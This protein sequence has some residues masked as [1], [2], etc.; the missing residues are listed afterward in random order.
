M[1][2]P[3]HN[4]F[5]VKFANVNGTG[6]SSANGMFM[7][8][9]FRMGIP[10]VG[11]NY[12]PSNI[13]GLPTWYEIRASEKGYLSPSG[14]V[15]IMVAMNAQTYAEDLASV[16][17]GGYL[18]YDSSW[19]RKE[20]MTREDVT[21]LGVPLA[22]ICNEKFDTA[23]SRT[24][25]KNTAYVG[26]LAALLDM[27][28]A[29]IEQLLLDT[30]GA[31]KH[32]IDANKIALDM[33]FDYA[34]ENFKCPL[35]F[36]AQTTNKTD[37]HIIIDGNATAA[38]G[39]VFAGATVGSWYP[40][41]PST[42]LMDAFSGYCQSLRK[43]KETEKNNYSIIQA[44]DEL[45]AIGMA[46]GAGWNGARS[47]TPTSGPGISLMGEFLGF[48][49]YAEIP[50][51]VFD[52]QR[53]G[54]STGM[55]TRTQQCDIMAC[56][57]ASHGDTKH[58]CL[59]PANPE[60]AFYLSTEAFNLAEQLQTP[61]FVLSDLDIGMND[62]MVKD[63]EW[64]DGY[65]PKRG[66]VLGKEEL[67]EIETFYRYLDVDGDGITY[68][69][70]PGRH[71]KGAYFTRG[72]GHNRLGGYTENASD[73]QDVVDRLLVK[74]ETAK[75]LV[76]QPEISYSKKNKIGIISI[77]SCNDAI[78]ET[79]DV[80][81]KQGQALNYLRVKAFPF[82]DKVETFITQ[83]EQVFVIEQNRDGQLHHMLIAE[84]N[85]DPKKLKSLRFYNGIPIFAK[86]IIQQIEEEINSG[87]A[88]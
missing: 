34:K 38:L 49:Y 86:D 3:S 13:Q 45:A 37:G 39:C 76:P 55:P 10:V 21:V 75:T 44:E 65:E 15:D 85:A 78:R 29:V 53:T 40:I 41:T 5:T 84:T 58:V 23:R 7:K 61:V 26:V 18:I 4:N 87:K 19:P 82:N 59:Y 70:I 28:V 67:D 63:L 12:F 62:W 52:V 25:M 51:V 46:L 2:K 73:Y 9:I 11:K 54:P 48:G 60:E 35:S 31:K 88:A 42:S 24:L 71:P 20:L 1:S 16:E 33:G 47:F 32:L 43:D 64:E 81:K 69:T 74:W 27:D 8:S 83:H 50:T 14:T 36:S 79:R 22:R 17:P 68:R 57:Y 30:F 72:S 80:L 66:K 56:A 77:G 6:S